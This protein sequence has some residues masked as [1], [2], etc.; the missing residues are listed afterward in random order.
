MLKRLLNNWGLKLISLVL[1]FLLWFLVVEI[2]DP[3]DDQ[4]MGNVVVRLTNTQLLDAEN[5]V[6]E[7]LDNTNVV[8]V[9]VYAPKSVLSQIRSSDITAEADISKLTDINTVPIDFSI[10]TI[11][12][13]TVTGSHDYVKL[14]IEE[15][16]SKYV[17]LSSKTTGEVADGYAVTALT[18]DQNRIE[19]SGPRSVVDQI[20]Y[21]GAEIDVTDASSNLVAN[22]DIALYNV[23]GEEIDQSKITK[24]VDHVKMSVEILAVKEVPITLTVDSTPEKGYMIS[25]EPISD[26]SKVKLAGSAYNLSRVTEVSVPAD[27]LDLTGATEDKEFTLDIREYLPE[28]TKL[29]D[30]T[31]SG[32]VTVT[33]PIEQIVE[34]TF[35]GSVSDISI[36]NVP[37]GYTAEINTSEDTGYT[38]ELSGLKE[39]IETLRL[40]G[41]PK[42]KINVG[43][44]LEEQKLEKPRIGINYTVPVTFEVDENITIKNTVSVK[45][46][47]RDAEE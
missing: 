31:F 11:S 22:V 32:K 13:A 41:G 33:V 16:A 34:R 2:G 9:T 36:L 15:K 40:N 45:L 25:G 42:G 14:N 4:D 47:F 19:V 6:Y 23:L 30:S 12:G 44:W 35:T 39:E 8:R 26:V 17:S 5:K 43:A 37:S 24:N 20:R 27:V 7:I 1:A 10:P 28:N 29:A 21:A 38:L 46:I 18:P 3:K